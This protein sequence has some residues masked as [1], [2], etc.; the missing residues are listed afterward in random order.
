[1]LVASAFWNIRRM[2][3]IVRMGM[4]WIDAC[5]FQLCRDALPD[6]TQ[7]RDCG[8]DPHQCCSGRKLHC[9]EASWKIGN[10]NSEVEPILQLL[11]SEI[12]SNGTL[13]S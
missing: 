5:V 6:E 9:R 1:M 8:D 3:V 11:T 13:P 2:L 10:I 4:R 7:E 12:T